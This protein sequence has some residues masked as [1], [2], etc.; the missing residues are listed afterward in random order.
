MTDPTTTTDETLD[1]SF[2]L[3]THMV[4]ADQQIHNKELKYLYALNSTTKLGRRTKEEKE[5]ILIQDENLIPVDFVA[6]RVLSEQQNWAMGQILVM[7]Y[8][9]GFYSPLEHQMVEQVAEIWGW[10]KKRLQEFVKYA[11]LENAVQPIK[12]DST[13]RNSLWNTQNYKAAIEQCTKIAQQ[14]FKFTESALQAAKTTLDNLKIDINIE[15]NLLTIKHKS[16]DNAK[17]QT[18]QEVT[19]Q[20]ETTKQSLEVEIVKKIQDVCESLNSKQRALNYFS[21]AFMGKTKAGKS[22]LHAIM[23]GEGWDSIGVGKQRTTRLNRV[24]ELE[25]IRIIDTPGI[26]APGGQ[27]D[28]EIAQSVINEAD[29]ICY[30]VTND[31]IQETEFGFLRLLKENAKPLIILLNVHKNFR[32]SRRGYY[33]LD[34]FLKNPDKLFYLDGASGLGGHIERI[35]RYGQQHYGNDYFDIIPVM[36]LAAQLSSESE[37]QDNQEQLF[38][39]SQIQNF[40]DEIRQS[41]VNYGEIRRSQTLLGCT[42]VELEKPYK[43]IEQ[44]AQTFTNSTERLKSKHRNIDKQIAQ[45]ANDARNSLKNEIDS[46]FKDALNAIPSFAETHW[47]S[48]E[49]EMKREWQTKLKN[50]SFEERLNTAY[51]K[52]VSN[53]AKEVQES[54][55]EI[56]RELQ[57]IAKLG[58]FS[59]SLN[60]QDTSDER[61]FFRIGGG[62]LG[63]AGVVM[64]FIPPLAAIGLIVGI[65]GSVISVIGGF[66]KSKQEKRREAVQN[67]STALK[68]QIKEFKEKTVSN[69]LEQ[70]DKTCHEVKVNIDNYFEELIE[71]LDAIARKLNLAQSELLGKSLDVLNRAYAKRLV[72]WCCKKYEPLTHDSIDA[73]IAK[74]TRNSTDGMN[75]V[76]KGIIDIKIDSDAIQQII[77]ESVTFEKQQKAISKPHYKTEEIMMKTIFKSVLN[78]FIQDDWNYKEIEPGEAISLEVEMKNSNYTCYAIVNDE[79]KTFR[80]YS[81][82]PIKIPKNKHLQ[83]AEFLTRA[84]YGLILGNFEMDFADG[85]LRYKTSILVGDNE[86]DYPVIKTIVYSSLSTM[87]NYFPAIMKVIYGGVSAEEAVNQIEEEQENEEEE[88]EEAA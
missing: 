15:L 23:T 52:T 56:G 54:L 48:S 55:E 7:A 21:I 33:E 68:N 66:F 37:H 88:E 63:L 19:K 71:G 30:V 44:Q 83:I 34:K 4:C 81:T 69:A 59:F 20:L 43:W 49:S 78:F 17:A 47:D 60:G 32:D 3:V 85:E 45:A 62:I 29:I 57:L 64:A 26:G 80:F 40:F 28:E 12:E 16:S 8:V 53:F 35:R 67:I 76:T 51:Q 11:E 36:L 2:L 58:N 18:A 27:T 73:A 79:N 42:A 25:N 77:Q 24:Y 46:I 50:I 72:D 22:T 39:A 6:Q 84:N 10:S 38:Q 82:S 86:L 41:I 14:D 65:V 75:I 9:D 1:Y 31:S 13:A 61:N 87:D 70:L 5:K 74:V